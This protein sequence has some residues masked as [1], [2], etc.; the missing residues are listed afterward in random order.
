MAGYKISHLLYKLSC[1]FFFRNCLLE[2]KGWT[3][4]RLLRAFVNREVIKTNSSAAYVPLFNIVYCE[5]CRVTALFSASRV[6]SLRG[7][8]VCWDF[9]QRREWIFMG[10]FSELDP[11]RCTVCVCGDLNICCTLQ[12]LLKSF[13]WAAQC[14]L[15]YKHITFDILLNFT[16]ASVCLLFFPVHFSVTFYISAKKHRYNSEKSVL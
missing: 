11:W 5:R 1:F 3:G 9:T 14:Q 16:G 10:L 13:N 8:K 2:V 7:D 6:L 12:C 15:H 4:S